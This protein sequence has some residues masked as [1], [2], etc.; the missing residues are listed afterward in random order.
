MLGL[1]LKQPFLILPSLTLI[2]CAKNFSPFTK[3]LLRSN[4]MANSLR[5]YVISCQPSDDRLMTPIRVIGFYVASV[6]RLRALQTHAC[7]WIRSLTFPILL[8]QAIQFELMTKVMDSSSLKWLS[9][10]P[11]TFG[12]MEIG[13][14]P[15]TLGN[16]GNSNQSG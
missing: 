14:H 12:N 10:L 15:T 8:H 7:Q 4:S 11:T 1:L 5:V 13:N 16:I 6:L 9:P 3:A 2:N